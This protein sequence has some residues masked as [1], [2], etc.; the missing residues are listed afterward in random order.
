MT[1]VL[2]VASLVSTS[3]FFTSLKSS[4]KSKLEAEL[5][6]KG[7]FVLTAI[8]RLIRSASSIADD[9]LSCSSAGIT[10]N[11]ITIVDQEGQ[12][13]TFICD[14][15][16]GEIASQSANSAVLLTGV[17]LDCSQFVTCQ[18]IGPSSAQITVRFTISSGNL[19]QEPDRASQLE[20]ETSVVPRNLDQ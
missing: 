6:E 1:T 18:W 20:F 19:A 8:T 16:A 4:T 12:E 17:N 7:Q 5:K 3:I 9:D 15:A 13:T 11:Q 10:R 2:A 14:E